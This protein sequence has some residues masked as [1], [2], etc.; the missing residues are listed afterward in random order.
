MVLCWTRRV[1]PQAR[2]ALAGGGLDGSLPRADGVDVLGR[3]ADLPAVVG[4]ARA[5]VVPIWEGDRKSTRL[6]SSH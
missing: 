1:R 5:V 3:V 4:A 6:N 2:L